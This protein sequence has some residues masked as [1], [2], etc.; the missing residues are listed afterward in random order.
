[1]LLLLTEQGVGVETLETGA[2]AMAFKWCFWNFPLGEIGGERMDTKSVVEW[3][4]VVDERL[5]RS[6]EWRI[7]FG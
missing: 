1:M 5:K 6:I 4:E 2:E 3:F 7:G